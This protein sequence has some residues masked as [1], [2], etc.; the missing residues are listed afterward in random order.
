MSDTA[1]QACPPGKPKRICIIGVGGIARVYGAALAELGTA[2][3]VL[4]GACCRTEEKGRQFAEQFGC[5]WYVCNYGR[6]TAWQSRILS[7]RNRDDWCC[8]GRC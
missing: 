5:Q 7:E 6:L 2:A 3:S 4:V 8:C 1:H